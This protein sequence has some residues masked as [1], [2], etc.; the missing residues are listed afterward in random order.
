MRQFKKLRM[1]KTP[2][3]SLMLGGSNPKSTRFEVVEAL[4]EMGEGIQIWTRQQRRVSQRLT[5]WC[6]E[7]KSRGCELLRVD[8]T[9]ASRGTISLSKTS[10]GNADDVQRE[11]GLKKIEMFVVETSE[12]NGVL[13]MI[14]DWQGG[15]QFIVGESWLSRQWERIHGAP[16]VFIRRMWL[17]KEDIRR[18]PIFRTAIPGRSAGGAGSDVVELEKITVRYRQGTG[19][20]LKAYRAQPTFSTWCGI[21]PGLDEISFADFLVG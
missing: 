8:L 20:M 16:I 5:S 2:K 1:H 19:F 3:G 17:A 4:D 10:S 14:W 18:G 12:G 9:T 7:T 21:N 11:L 15:R 6:Y 13:H